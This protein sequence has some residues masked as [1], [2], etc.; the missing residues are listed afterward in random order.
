MSSSAS[1]GSGW[2]ALSSLSGAESVSLSPVYAKS[3]R[4]TVAAA[5][6]APTPAPAAAPPSSAS[7]QVGGAAQPGAAPRRFSMPFPPP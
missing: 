6:A 3:Y 1:V 7:S 5:A 4:I 2:G